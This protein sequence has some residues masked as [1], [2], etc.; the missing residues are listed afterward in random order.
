MR[1]SAISDDQGNVVGVNTEGLGN[2]GVGIIVRSQ[3]NFLNILDGQLCFPVLLLLWGITASLLLTIPC[4]VAGCSDKQ[5]SRI[6][7]TRGVAA[8]QD[9]HAFRDWANLQGVS[10]SVGH[11]PL[12]V[13]HHYP[14]TGAIN[15]AGPKPAISRCAFFNSLP[16]A[17]REGGFQIPVHYCPGFGTDLMAQNRVLVFPLSCSEFS[18]CGSRFG[19]V[20]S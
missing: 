10:Q 8:V 15:T 17:G 11:P 2:F 19:N 14:V 20:H 4:V 9:A 6:T 3:P 12:K 7:A 5:M 1:P 18:E 16:E 13:T